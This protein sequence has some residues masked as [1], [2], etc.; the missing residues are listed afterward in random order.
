M[1]RNNWNLHFAPIDDS[2]AQGPHETL[3]VKRSYGDAQEAMEVLD[4]VVRNGDADIDPDKITQL[5]AIIHERGRP[6]IAIINNSFMAPAGEWKHLG[7]EDN[8]QRIKNVI[9]S[10][11]CIEIPNDPGGRPYAGT[12][13]VVGKDLL[14][15]NRHV[16][17]IF[18]QGWGLKGLRFTPGRNAAVD[19]VR[20]L[21]H[22]L[23]QPP[24][25]L[26]VTDIKMIHPYWDMALL[27]V[28][29]LPEQ[30][31]HLKLS[32]NDPLNMVGDEVVVIG[33][34]AQDSRSNATVQ[35]RIFNGF[36][37]VKRMLPGKL[38]GRIDFTYEH[39][40]QTVNTLGHDSSTLGGNS[41]SAVISVA[42]G[43]VVGL[44]FAGKYMESNYAVSMLDLAADSRIRDAG[45]VFAGRVEPRNDFYGP[46]WSLAHSGAE[47]PPSGNAVAPPANQNPGGFSMTTDVANWTIPLNI[48]VSIGTP[49]RTPSQPTPPAKPNTQLSDKTAD[50]EEGLLSRFKV[51]DHYS[52]FSLA[53]LKHSQADWQTA[54]STALA[55]YLA[56]SSKYTIKKHLKQWGFAEFQPVFNDGTE[57]F[58]ARSK[59]IALISF[60]GTEFTKLSD[61]MTD[62]NAWSTS[63]S[64][65]EV[66]RGFL[67]G[68]Q[69]VEGKLLDLVQSAGLPV[70]LTGHSLG[71]ALAV[72]A[73]AEWASNKDI[74]IRSIYTYGQPGAGKGR[75]VNWMTEHYA[76]NY[77]RFVNDDDIVPKVPPTYQHVGRLIRFGYWGD[78]SAAAKAI[79]RKS[80]GAQAAD[81]RSDEKTTM[82]NQQEFD[83]IR[84][85]L[86]EERIRGPLTS[87][88]EGFLPVPSFSD[89]KMAGYIRKIIEFDQ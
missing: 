37:E 13:F 14:M 64:Y 10:V 38:N 12:G 66:H 65:G 48:S 59:D 88:E 79:F 35:N 76:G 58:F 7:D 73:A 63:R 77:F 60:R 41:G 30:H 43:E 70:V 87:A 85:R 26:S 84:L 39:S 32:T 75:F 36:F 8:K 57:C 51:E 1:P 54:R 9:P 50:T 81:S 56:Y 16:A 25:H 46:I 27:K 34:P 15:T 86:L 20:E 49:Q 53:S 69:A 33:Y 22:D 83:Q 44:H 61:W 17:Q 4:V 24:V 29:G 71:G 21:P 28:E 5:E 2:D 55:S 6:A 80:V 52:R 19:F 72:I 47:Q 67:G 18:A 68:L 31:P 23:L 45:V 62:F 74:D 40:Q 11:G 89:H 42:T 82:L 78:I 3:E